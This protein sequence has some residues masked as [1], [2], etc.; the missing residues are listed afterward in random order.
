MNWLGKSGDKFTLRFSHETVDLT[1]PAHFRVVASSNSAEV[2]SFKS[3][4]EVI[5]PSGTVKVDKKKMV[6]FDVNDA[7]RSTAAKSFKEDSYD[8]WDKQAVDYHDQYAKNNPTPYGYGLSDLNYYGSYS[9]FPGYGML[10]QPYFAGAGWNPFMD[11]AWSFY[12]GMGYMWASAYPWGWMPYYYGNWLYAPG[13]GWGWQPGA[14]N[15]W[16]GGVHYMGAGRR[17][18]CSCRTYRHGRHSGRRKRR[19]SSQ[20]VSSDEPTGQSWISR[21][22]NSA[23]IGRGPASPE[24]AS[25]E[26]GLCGN[27]FSAA[28][29]RELFPFQRIRCRGA[30]CSREWGRW[31]RWHCV[32]R[33]R[34]RSECWWTSVDGGSVFQRRP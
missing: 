23:R 22:G 1:Q 34:F 25:G 32:R 6:T 24:R 14:F 9:N 28:V 15:G 26:N 16:R 2:A 11:G 21:D 3:D 29:C 18:S 31:P 4:V 20:R 8:D 19:P 17:V 7:D 30:A 5:G 13:L 33:T 27:T 12:P 10:W